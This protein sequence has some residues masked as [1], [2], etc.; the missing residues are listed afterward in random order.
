MPREQTWIITGAAH[1]GEAAKQ[2]P[3]LPVG[4]IVG[5][6]TGRDTAMC[7]ALGAALIA[8]RDPEGVMAVMPADHVIEPAREFGRALHAAEQLALDHPDALITF[9]IRPTSAST[10]F[11]Y[12]HQGA[13]A[14]PRQGCSV[15]KVQGFREKPQQ[16]IADEYLASGEYFWNSGI[17]V[18][19]VSAILAE[20]DRNKPKLL[21]GAQR[22]AAAWGTPNQDEVFRREYEAA[23]KISIDFAVMEQAREV[24]VVQAPYTWDD[25]GSW[26]ALERHNPQDAQ[27]NTVQASHVGEETSRCVIVADKTL[28]IARLD[29]RSR[30][31]DQCQ[32]H[33]QRSLE[34]DWK[35]PGRARLG[36]VLRQRS[37]RD[38][39]PE[40]GD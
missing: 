11:G 16:K 25:V 21:A 38:T 9:G 37:R 31:S 15:F 19:K 30:D 6:P 3:D 27:G 1:Q 32:W 22:I 20:L 35:H 29:R 40:R 5:E 23:E 36:E 7:I 10:N 24:L 33:L 13:A 26:L 12:I 18:W 14:P 4:Q 2:L 8:Q 39:A 17:F 28:Q 34:I